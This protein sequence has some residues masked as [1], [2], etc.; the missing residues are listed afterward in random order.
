VKRVY[1]LSME[2]I[3]GRQ[4]QNNLLNN[5]LETNYREALSDIGYDLVIKKLL[6]PI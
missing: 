3:L 6:N 4:M 5:D 2:Y 1:F